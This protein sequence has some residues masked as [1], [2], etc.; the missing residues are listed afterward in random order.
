MALNCV[1]EMLLLLLLLLLLLPFYVQVTDG[2]AKAKVSTVRFH[3]KVALGTTWHSESESARY[4][5]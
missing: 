3:L 1:V 2:V 5:Q 4:L